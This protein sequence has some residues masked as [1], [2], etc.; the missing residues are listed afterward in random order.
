MRLPQARTV[1]RASRVQGLLHPGARAH[2]AH[3]LHVPFPGN[4]PLEDPS[5]FSTLWA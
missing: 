1:P 2:S 3:W 4:R 5:A